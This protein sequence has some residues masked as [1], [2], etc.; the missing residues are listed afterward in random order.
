[1][2]LEHAILEWMVDTQ[3]PFDVVD[4]VKWKQMWKI[5]LNGKLCPIKSQQ[6]ARSRIE[7]EFIRSQYIIYEELELTA[8]T[9]S[10]SLDVWKAPNGKYIFAIIVHWTTEDFEDR[11]V[12]LHFGHLKGSHTGENLAR[13]TLQVLE[14]FN[15][16]EK[17]VAITGDNAS[18]NPSLC[19]HLHKLLSKDFTDNPSLVDTMF[20]DRKLMQFKGD[21]SFVRCMAHILNLVAKAILKELKAGS[22]KE[23]K[24]LIQVM[25]EKKID[26]FKPEDTPKSAIGRLRL[27]VLWLL[28]SE[29]RM[30]KFREYS[31]IGLDYDVDTRW[32]ALLK[33][34]E[35]CIRSRAAVDKMCDH[36]PALALLRLSQAEWTFIG[37]I[38]QVMAP[39]Y[40]KTL[41]VS[42][43]A[44]TIT[45][46]TEIYWEIDDI[47]DEVIERQGKYEHVNNQ[48]R[49]AV[50]V[51]RRVLEEYTAKMDSETI[52][53]YAASV[54]DPRVKTEWLKNH[55]KDNADNVIDDLRSHFKEISPKEEKLPEQLPQ[56]LP[57]PPISS[58][59]TSSFVGRNRGFN[60]APSRRRMLEKIQQA[61]YS[62]PATVVDEIDDWLSSAPIQE[63]IPEKMTAEQDVKWLLSWWRA[64]RFRYPRMAKIAR[65]Y[66]SVPASEVGVERLFSRGRDL[67]GLRRFALQP[68]TMRMLTMLK[69]F[70]N[71][72]YF[73]HAI[74]SIEDEDIEPDI[75]MKEGSI[76][77]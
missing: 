75:V 34:L 71:D 76:R 31:D 1:M 12:V 48:I 55:L 17:L 52:I 63:R 50:I 21:E 41:L 62:T 28:A 35:L 11:Q 53:P 74:K 51:G 56:H 4:G 30:I 36:Y 15:L 29:Q 61:H 58:S 43:D 70:Y 20:E 6:V 77:P 32:N 26:T 72:T 14:Y 66:L 73:R 2:T 40:E 39:F 13:E 19:R 7:D 68:A 46:S 10:F 42:Q 37:E 57:T 54:L 16:R 23:A 67:L 18:N 45:M 3:Q 22:H 49:D 64:N 38:H 8:E 25:S 44:P 27:I 33:M 9:V 5:A 59:S 24:K 47:M 69:A 60:V 65:R